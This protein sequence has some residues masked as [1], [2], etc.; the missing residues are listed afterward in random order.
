[1]S[2]HDQPSPAELRGL[3]R[4]TYARSHA[5][6][7]E[8]LRIYVAG[9][10]SAPTPAL[11]LRNVRRAVRTGTALARLGH[12]PFVPHLTHYWDPDDRL[13][14]YDW[15]TAYDHVW[16]RLCEALYWLS[17][18]PGADRERALAEALGLPIYTALAD[19]PAVGAAAGGA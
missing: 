2:D 8:P 7:V 3:P 19:V 18:S 15:W 17:P 13:L 6:P 10:L 16:L 5:L 1:M 14:G 11:R 4:T 12:L 9:P